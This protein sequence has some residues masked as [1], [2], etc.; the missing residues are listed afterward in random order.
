MIAQF[1]K[2][3]PDEL[4]YSMLAR[5]YVRSGHSAYKQCFEDLYLKKTRPDV[6]YLNQMTPDLLAHLGDI[7]NVIIK[8]TMF[9][10][11]R[12]VP[13]ARKNEVFHLLK[14]QNN[15]YQ[16]YVF[17]PKIRR[18]IRYCPACAAEDRINYGETYWHRIPQIYGLQV[19]PVHGC[20]LKDTEIPIYSKESASLIPAE[21]SITDNYSSV[22][23]VTEYEHNAAKYAASVFSSDMVL[24][25]DNI[26]E[27]LRTRTHKYRSPSGKS[28]CNQK[29]YE[30]FKKVFP[31][32]D[33]KEEWQI[34]K[35]FNGVRFHFI[36]ICNLAFYLGIRKQDLLQSHTFITK[37]NKTNNGRFRSY[38]V[39]W[40]TKD[41]MYLPKVEQA[42]N[43][44]ETV[45][46]PVHMTCGLISRK[47]G[48]PHSTLSRG[49]LPIC[50]RLI[51]QHLESKEQFW[52]RKLEWAY[53]II[54]QQ[55]LPLHKTQLRKIT[56]IEFV[57]MKRALVRCASIMI[58][59]D[60]IH[61]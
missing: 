12:F 53:Q 47:A 54:I 21:V 31:G 3:Y 43:M 11:L 38:D 49:N 59:A 55:C 34:R 57:D 17:K 5:Y 7:E 35:I 61:L 8:H 33:I 58:N 1:P 29:L 18:Y 45:D 16:N 27:F 56:N 6:E 4:L 13:P 10:E 30:D 41:L 2:P 19:C 42:I 51:S 39:D 44:L 48:I 32:S 37:N 60:I 23:L 26:G 28:I 22:A 36:E 52:A 46:K 20:K 15:R 40:N 24:V 9:P 14:Q 50:T 25:T